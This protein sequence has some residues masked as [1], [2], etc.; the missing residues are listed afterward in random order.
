[1][2]PV[3]LQAES[4]FHASYSL[5][6]HFN[7]WRPTNMRVTASASLIS[8]GLLFISYII[9]PSTCLGSLNLLVPLESSWKAFASWQ[10]Q[11]WHQPNDAWSCYKASHLNWF[12]IKQSHF[13]RR[14]SCKCKMFAEHRAPP[15]CCDPHVSDGQ[16]ENISRR[17]YRDV[18]QRVVPD[19]FTSHRWV[20]H[21]RSC[22]CTNTYCH[23]H[24]V[25][26]GLSEVPKSK[27]KVKQMAS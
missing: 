11:D 22:W 24:S 12:Y 5:S 3:T 23:R 1:M 26:S 21:P 9:R 19:V 10:Q 27:V 4:R 2:T 8:T 25:C 6:L 13:S 16:T 17:I 20:E 15:L 7:V 18:R 14:F